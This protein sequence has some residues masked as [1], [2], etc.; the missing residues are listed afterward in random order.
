MKYTLIGSTTSPYVRRLRIYL[1]NLECDF[2]TMSVFEAKD[3]ATLKEISP[4][5][6]VPILKINQSGSSQYLYESRVIFNYINKNHF[7]Q[8]LSIQDENF[9]S[10]L[11]GVNDSLITLFLMK[12]SQ[13]TIE[14]DKR[15]V[16]AQHERI[17]AGLSF[18]NEE[19]LTKKKPSCDYIVISLYCLIDWIK[20]RELTD[21]SMY[22]ELEN[23]HQE[24]S[25]LEE[26]KLTD[27]R[28]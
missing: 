17:Q 26:Y 8:D 4:I 9:L 7:K 21:L 5:L 3:R 16:M 20:F 6:K 28:S 12:L 19:I 1:R 22:R 24:L 2:E 10:V 13:M 25:S 27:P 23:I 15:F 11:D 14:E 18:L